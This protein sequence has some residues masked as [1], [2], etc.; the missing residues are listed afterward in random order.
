MTAASVVDAGEL[1]PDTRTLG[2]LM[3]AVEGL[4]NQLSAFSMQ[5]LAEIELLKYWIQVAI[6]QALDKEGAT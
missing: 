5:A 2:E 3:A 4:R 1:I 6:E